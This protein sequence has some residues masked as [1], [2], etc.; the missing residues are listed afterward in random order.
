MKDTKEETF[1]GKG[2]ER[3]AMRGV[4]TVCGTKMMKFLPKK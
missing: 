2:G 1:M 4:C 3:R